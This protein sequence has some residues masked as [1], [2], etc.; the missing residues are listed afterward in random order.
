MGS[1][2]PGTPDTASTTSNTPTATGINGQQQNGSAFGNPAMMMPGFMMYPMPMMGNYNPLGMNGMNMNLMQMSAMQMPMG[3]MQVPVGIGMNG[4]PMGM[5]AGMSGVNGMQMGAMGMSGM[6]M[7]I[8]T[9]MPMGAMGMPMGMQMPSSMGFQ[10]NPQSG[11]TGDVEM[12]PTS[13]SSD[14]SSVAPAPTPIAMRTLQ[15]KDASRVGGPG[16]VSIAR[17]PE[18]PEVSS[19]LKS[20]MEEEAKKKEKKLERNRD[21]ARESRKKQ[22]TYVETLENGIKRL[23][24]NRDLV[25]SY[26]WGVSGPGFGPLPCP[27]SPQMFDWKN[28]VQVVTG[29]SEAFANIQNPTTF[30]A[31]MQL[32]RQRRV[33]AMRTDD[34]AR[35]VWKCFVAIGRQ[36]AELRR[37]II[38]VQMLR[39]FSQNTLAGEVSEA[40]Q[41][42]ADQ[43]LQL[44]CLAQTS[45]NEEVVEMV[46]LFKAFFALRNEALRLNLMSPDLERYFRDSCSVEQLHRL[47]QFSETHR[48]VIED[49]LLSS[50]ALSLG[51]P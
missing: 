45:F 33:L 46:A 47:L 5:P 1:A 32:N 3:A 40:L 27:N 19:I 30:R 48:A 11:V 43:K 24:I 41:L 44:Q 15:P 17:K 2:T 26:R 29:Q 8:N 28:R 25:A 4:M 34:R 18:E 50:T 6:G 36:L 20:L 12:T 37:R 31:L 9:T 39:V 49:A 51:R 21:S 14:N 22:Q 16:F 23:Q 42:S 7:G 10:V 38:Q 13:A 35:A